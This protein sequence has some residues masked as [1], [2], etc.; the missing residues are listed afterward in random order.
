MV[1]QLKSF[2]KCLSAPSFLMVPLNP[3]TPKKLFT[4]NFFLNT[5]IMETC[6]VNAVDEEGTDANF[7]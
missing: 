7:S 1:S 5:V 2:A 3:E 6:F 4:N